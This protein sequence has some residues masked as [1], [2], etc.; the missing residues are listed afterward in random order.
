MILDVKFVHALLELHREVGAE[1]L[2]DTVP[3]VDAV[4]SEI[5]ADH[6]FRLIFLERGRG[7]LSDGGEQDG[8]RRRRGLSSLLGSRLRFGSLRACGRSEN[9]GDRECDADER[10]CSGVARGVLRKLSEGPVHV[11]G[12]V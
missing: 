4:G 2:A 11:L 10:G 9:R 1:L 12:A 6:F 7:L 8:L 5:G 3:R